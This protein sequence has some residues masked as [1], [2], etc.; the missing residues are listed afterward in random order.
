VVLDK[1][2]NPEYDSK[3]LKGINMS[4][5][6][7]ANRALI[8]AH[9]DYIKVLKKRIASRD[10]DINFWKQ[11]VSN[12]DYKIKQYREKVTKLNEILDNALQYKNSID[13]DYVLENLKETLNK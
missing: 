11:I 8:D 2:N 7:I 5:K 6:N 12:K 4:I 13:A 10:E 9:K 1:L 3:L